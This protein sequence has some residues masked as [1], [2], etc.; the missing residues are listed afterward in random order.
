VKRAVWRRQACEDVLGSS[1]TAVVDKS[2]SPPRPLARD[3]ARRNGWTG[4]AVAAPTR[5]AETNH[6]REVRSHR[7]SSTGCSYL[8]CGA[9]GFGEQ[10]ANRSFSTTVI[11]L[12]DLREPDLAGAIDEVH[13]G[14][15]PVSVRV[16][17]DEVVVQSDGILEPVLPHGTLDVLNGP[18]ECELGTVD[19][20]DREVG[21]VTIVH[22]T[23]EL[24]GVLAVHARE[25]P[26]LEQDD[27]VAKGREPQRLAVRGVEPRIDADS[28]GAR[29]RTA[30]RYAT[31]SSIGARE[32]FR[33]GKVITRL[34]VAGG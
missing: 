19:A 27:A 17:S 22:S 21:L 10:R 5:D 30:N 25:G 12:T 28:S 24:E 13:G 23:Q 18:L 11:T 6:A 14:P 1:R 7:T 9:D 4:H 34:M 16:P 26:E 31:S 32:V 2:R 33:G 8:G 3:S 20:D 15:V 29:P